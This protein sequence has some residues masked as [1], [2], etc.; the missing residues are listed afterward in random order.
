MVRVQ[1]ES[2]AMAKYIALGYSREPPVATFFGRM[3]RSNEYRDV[4]YY[5]QMRLPSRR[6]A[7]LAFLLFSELL[8]PF[9]RLFLL[10][11]NTCG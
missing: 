4:G 9:S 6:L 5:T 11:S 8:C 2:K 10:L 7:L 3:E 1:N